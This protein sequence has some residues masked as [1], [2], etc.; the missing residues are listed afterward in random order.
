LH[1][2]KLN[3]DL[4]GAFHAA[5]Y[6]AASCCCDTCARA[7]AS[8]ILTSL[9]RLCLQQPECPPPASSLPSPLRRLLPSPRFKRAASPTAFSTSSLAAACAFFDADAPSCSVTGC[10][11]RPSR[12][13]VLCT[14]SAPQ[15]RQCS[16]PAQRPPLRSSRQ[17]LHPSST[18]PA[19]GR[20]HMPPG[21]ASFLSA[22]MSV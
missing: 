12:L 2:A 22:S 17:G 16:D 13:H 7:C 19:A 9:W 3:I 4:A 6:A 5:S 15:A 14:R 21:S 1:A 8:P 18:V 11:R 20:K 10:R